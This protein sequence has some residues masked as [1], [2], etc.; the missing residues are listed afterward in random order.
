MNKKL[1]EKTLFDV[2]YIFIDGISRSGKG[3]IAPFVS[4]FKNVEHWNQSFNLDRLHFLLETDQISE[5]GFRYFFETDLIKDTWFS[6][7][8][9][10][11]NTN[12]HDISSVLN[13]AD[14]KK[15]LNRFDRKDTPQVFEQ[16]KNEVEDNK[17]I[18]P[19]LTDD[20]IFQ[21]KL[22]KKIIP[23]SKFIVSIRHPI[24][25]VFAWERS[26]RGVRFGTDQRYLNPTFEHNGYKN[27]PHFALDQAK[28][29]SEANSV[30]KCILSINVLQKNYNEIFEQKVPDTMYVNFD[31]FSLNPNDKLESM[32][33]F[34]GTNIS[35]DLEKI[36]TRGRFP[37][38]LDLDLHS[39]KAEAIFLSI[40]GEFRN[41]LIALCE[42]YS[43]LY[44]DPYSID[45]YKFMS[46]KIKKI[47]FTKL[48]NDPQYIDG[49][50]IN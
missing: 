8:G 34:I 9:R 18:F 28:E 30:E 14:P 29:Y 36:F 5:A 47:D 31:E 33:R 21:Q 48:T 40:R 44:G 38:S 13:S 20:F 42:Q 41:M 46:T 32:E 10:N 15:Y 39:R 19:Y 12:A 26:G 17:L 16:I 49:N 45:Y 22:I 11:V 3:A 7:I 4:S 35:N 6:M 27:I 43:D 50:R 37:R 24:E 23:K 25:L 2:E 1:E